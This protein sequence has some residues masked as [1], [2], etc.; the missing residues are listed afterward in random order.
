MIQSL[1]V[2]VFQVIDGQESATTLCRVNLGGVLN[3]ANQGTGS[4]SFGFPATGIK[5]LRVKYMGNAVYDGVIEDIT[6]T[7]TKG[8]SI[9]TIT[10][11]MAV[12]TVTGQT[13]QVSVL[14][15]ADGGI[16]LTPTGQVYV[17]DQADNTIGCYIVLAEGIGSCNLVFNQAGD[18]QVV[19]QYLAGTD[20]N[21]ESSLSAPFLH[22]VTQ[23]STTT[24]FT[25]LPSQTYVGQDI[26]FSFKSEVLPPGSG[27]LSGE[28]VVMDGSNVFCTGFES[29]WG[30]I[31]SVAPK[32]FKVVYDPADSDPNYG[33]SESTL[34]S[35]TPLPSATKFT[36]FSA[37]TVPAGG[38]PPREL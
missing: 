25:S 5:T 8:K 38:I 29:C 4:C 20:D 31:D 32:A 37:S 27:T 36:L 28:S 26:T 10:T 3:E 30:T 21:F 15:R 19:A 16:S 9:T 6:L 34:V 18:R 11:N 12:P 17:Y 24:V 23:A 33:T 13:L 22:P 1:E 35:Y 2:Q 7:V 14:V